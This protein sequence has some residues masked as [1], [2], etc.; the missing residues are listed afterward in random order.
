M[1]QRRAARFV[2][3]IY[4]RYASV[5]DMLQHLQWDTLENRRNNFRAIAMYKIHNNLVDINSGDLLQPA[6]TITRGHPLTFKHLQAHVDAFKYSFYPS[7]IK[8]WNSLPSEVV[9]SSNLEQ[10]KNNLNL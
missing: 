1:V 9:L 6:S 4:E 7:A 5:S 3:G 2:T 8:I 10:F